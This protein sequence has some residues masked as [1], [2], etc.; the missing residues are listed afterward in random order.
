MSCLITALP[1]MAGAV[2]VGYLG[3]RTL[4]DRYGGEPS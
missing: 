1:A 3:A 2:A 4:D